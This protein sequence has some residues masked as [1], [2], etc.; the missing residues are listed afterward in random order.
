MLNS[1]DT[2]RVLLVGFDLD[3][4]LGINGFGPTLPHCQVLE[5]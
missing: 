4:G 2:L 5:T 3:R 1:P